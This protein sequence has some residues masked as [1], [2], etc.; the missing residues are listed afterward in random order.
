MSSDPVLT[1]TTSPWQVVRLG[2]RLVVR[3]VR[4]TPGRFALAVTGALL[5]TGAIVASAL[6]VGDATDELIVPVLDGGEPV[7]GRLAPVVWLLLGVALWKAVGI[8]LRR[9]SATALQV[10]AQTELRRQLVRQLF[11]TSLR[12]YE[13][14]GVGDLLSTADVDTR[15]ATFV[16]APLPFAVGV[17]GLLVAAI[18]V[19]TGTDP[20]LGVAAFV[21]LLVVVAIDLRGAWLTFEGM[22]EAQRR[23]GRVAGVAHES[24]D[25]ALTVTSLGREDQER[26]R[27][28]AAA[29]HLRDQLIGVGRLWTSY[30]AVTE[31]LP[32]AGTIVILVLGS[33][34]VADG[35]LTPGELVRVAYLLSLLVVP[36]RMIGYLF[37]DTSQSV[38]G[39]RRVARVLEQQEPVTHG[40]VLPART[41][42]PAAISASEVTF[43]YDRDVPVLRN[44][45]LTI[46]PGTT[47]AVVG[48]TGSGKSSLAVLLARLWDPDSGALHLDGTDLRSLAPGVLPTEVAYVA[49]DTF[50]FDDSVLG[51]V[52]L[53]AP[54]DEAAVREALR[55]ANA[56]VFVEALPDGLDTPL[57]ERGATLSGGQRQRLALARALVRRPRLLVLDDATSAVDPS[58]EARILRG[59]KR[60]T[61]PSTVVV[62][63]ARRATI[64]LADR[65]VF[66]EDGRVRAT[67]THDELLTAVPGYARLLEAYEQDAAER[68]EQQRRQRQR[69]QERPHRDRPEGRRYPDDGA[70]GQPA[71]PGTP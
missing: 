63:A 14:H 66:L 22:E 40:G 12:A 18:V 1:T 27:F 54:V 36:V 62:V 25:G 35:A 68:A 53:G 61:R 17:V 23:R 59:L 64:L 26:E 16:L 65:I 2:A 30:R 7:D 48:P 57:G 32:S 69:T 37:W 34:R 33:L 56:E 29:E 41:A 46:E 49:Q 42:S 71:P 24:F 9:G 20:L 3:L 10:T 11:G 21:L 51:N 47:V 28:Q 45:E 43:S 8:V 13:Q 39:W 60:A 58:V 52:A 38:A 67:G 55:L 31:G 44:L 19:I 50:L 15:Q 70:E 5:F 4:G 6:V